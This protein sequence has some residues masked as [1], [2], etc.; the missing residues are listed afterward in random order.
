MERLSKSGLLPSFLFYAFFA[1]AFGYWIG[2]FVT[3]LLF[4][5]AAFLFFAVVTYP[6]PNIPD[7]IDPPEGMGSQGW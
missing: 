6:W 3:A 1:G 7:D 5:G 2:G 4:G